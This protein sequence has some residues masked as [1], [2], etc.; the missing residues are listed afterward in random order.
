MANAK[1]KKSSIS[2]KVS[3]PH[4][5]HH[6]VARTVNIHRN[7]NGRLGS[8]YSHTLSKHNHSLCDHES[9]EHSDMPGQV[10]AQDISD[11]GQDDLADETIQV[12]CDKEKAPVVSSCL[13][14]LFKF[15]LHSRN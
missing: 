11:D 1:K 8:N 12:Q 3:R 7:A 5:D 4:L 15:R 10:H 9:P 13:S 2:V 6:F 14:T